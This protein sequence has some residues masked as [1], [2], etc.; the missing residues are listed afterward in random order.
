M[1]AD[2]EHGEDIKRA[3]KIGLHP[4]SS[5]SSSNYSSDEDETGLTNY[6]KK[7]T[8]NFHSVSALPL[9]PRGKI[10]KTN[11]GKLK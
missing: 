4:Y 1:I 10:T 2:S 11:N 5:D 8:K 6:M 9:K 3:E 7:A